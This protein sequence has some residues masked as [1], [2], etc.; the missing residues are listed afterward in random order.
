MRRK[1]E[2]VKVVANSDKTWSLIDQ[3]TA[4]GAYIFSAL[5]ITIAIVKFAEGL[6]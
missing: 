6:F 2:R 4:Y 5:L 1:V 3:I